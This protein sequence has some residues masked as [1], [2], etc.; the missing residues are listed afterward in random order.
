MFSN[1]TEATL[2]RTRC[3]FVVVGL[4][5]L[6]FNAI[7]APLIFTFICSIYSITGYTAKKDKQ[8]ENRPA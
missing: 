5:F 7:K 2:L 4:D 1:K 8:G 3:R 6:S